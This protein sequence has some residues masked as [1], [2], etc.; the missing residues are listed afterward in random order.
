MIL[1]NFT[2]GLLLNKK[3]ALL[4]SSGES[5]RVNP[6]YKPCGC[7][8]CIKSVNCTAMQSPNNKY[9]TGCFSLFWQR[10]IEQ[11]FCMIGKRFASGCRPP[12]IYVANGVSYAQKYLSLK[13]RNVFLIRGL[14]WA[15]QADVDK[16]VF[17]GFKLARVSSFKVSK[18]TDSLFKAMA[19][20]RLK[21]AYR[22]PNKQQTEIKWIELRAFFLS[23]KG[24]KLNL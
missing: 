17:V 23:R 3:F 1:Q 12:F 16:D 24:F 4:F 14:K 11:F 21:L 19:G 6:V 5:M 2:L 22:K 15:G 9:S 18:L 8:Y 13:R 7:M 10:T 20:K